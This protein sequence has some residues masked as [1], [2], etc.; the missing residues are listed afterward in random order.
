MKATPVYLLPHDWD[1][2]GPPP[3]PGVPFDVIEAWECK[4][5]HDKCATADD[6]ITA[7]E[8]EA[9]DHYKEQESLSDQAYDEGRFGDD[10][11]RKADDIRQARG[12]K[13][14]WAL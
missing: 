6:C 10:L 12:E 5:G 8:E 4:A 14:K 7:L 9:Q 1:R 2:Y 13:R 3:K 11:Y